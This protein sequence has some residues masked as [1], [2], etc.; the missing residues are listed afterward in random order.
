M[1]FI[2]TGKTA[3]IARIVA[4]AAVSLGMSFVAQR[5]IALSNATSAAISTLA[6]AEPSPGAPPRIPSMAD[7]ARMQAISDRID[8]IADNLANA[9]TQ[10]FKRRRVEVDFG[11]K[12]NLGD[13]A[14]D[15]TEGG[16]DSTG[17]T[18][19]VAITGPGFF[20]LKMLPTRSDGTGYTR[21]GAF[22]QNNQGD[23]VVAI[24]PGYE[25]IPP[26]CIPPGA[27]NITITSDG[28]VQYT[29]AGRTAVATAGQIQLSQF[30]NA[31]ALGRAGGA[32]YTETPASGPP[33]VAPPGENGTG[34]LQQ[35][36]LEQSNVSPIKE[37]ALLLKAEQLLQLNGQAFQLMGKARP[38]LAG[39]DRQ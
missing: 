23:L 20:Q 37:W 15:M 34:Y 13:L 4:I 14:L 35:G 8:V 36:F 5:F 17:G 25:L 28:Q 27:S 39:L 19:D 30:A 2:M 21:N 9:Q 22:M 24:G 31:P 3:S 12:R 6:R 1:D 10:G 32:I 11:P 33:L 29:P 16:L 7:A 18:L 38:T 26:I